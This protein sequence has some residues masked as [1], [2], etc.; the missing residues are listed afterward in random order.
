M[1]H[2]HRDVQLDVRERQRLHDRLVTAL[3]VQR[4]A[5]ESFGEEF[6]E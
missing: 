6:M 5:L 4:T 2:L 3:E 1:E